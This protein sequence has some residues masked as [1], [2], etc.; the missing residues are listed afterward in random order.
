MTHRNYQPGLLKS[1]K[2]K[3]FQQLQYKGADNHS[4]GE[5][6]LFAILRTDAE[7]QE[8]MQLPPMTIEAV[9]G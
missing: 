2:V 4:E 1:A 7:V 6:F 3:L 5:K 9:L 8:Y